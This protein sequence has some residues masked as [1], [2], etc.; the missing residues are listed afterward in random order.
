M[1]ILGAMG[2]Q[3]LKEHGI[4]EIDP[5]KWYPHHLRAA[6]QE[7]PFSRYGDASLITFGYEMVSTKAM[8]DLWDAMLLDKGAINCDYEMVEMD[9]FLNIYMRTFTE[10]QASIIKGE[11]EGYGGR[12]KRIDANNMKLLSTLAPIVI[13]FSSHGVAVTNLNMVVKIGCPNSNCYVIKV[14]RV[15]TGRIAYTT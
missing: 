2:E 1:S 5:D 11:Y 10:M 12:V 15:R 13:G 4:Q 6:L 3:V 9:Q 7:V 14:S 8:G